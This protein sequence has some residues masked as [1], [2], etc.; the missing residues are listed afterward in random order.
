MAHGIRG[1]TAIIAMLIAATAHSA[2]EEQTPATTP[3]I[4]SVMPV[5]E[6]FTSSSRPSA[7]GHRIAQGA[8]S[9]LITPNVHVETLVESLEQ[10]WGM[11]LIDDTTLVV[12]ERP[13]RLLRVDL[14]DNTTSSIGGLPGVHAQGQGGLLDVALHPRFSE[15]RYL[16]LTYS[17]R[18]RG[19]TATHLGRG[20]LNAEQD[21]LE[22][23]EVLL[24]AGPGLRSNAHY[25]SRIAISDEGHVFI[26]TGDRNRKDFGP[27]HIAQ[28]LS[29][30][31]G[32]ILRVLD[33]GLIPADNPFV[34]D[35]R[36]DDAI[37][38]YG[39]RNPQGLAFHPQTGVLWSNEHGEFNGDEINIIERGGNYGWPIATWG[40]DYRTRERFAPTPPEVEDTI[41][42]VYWWSPEHP[43]GFPPSG[44]AF[45]FGDMFPEWS[46]H[47]LM[48]NLAHRYLGVFSVDRDESGEIAI[49]MVA[50]VLDGRHRIR[51]VLVHPDGS[52]FV[53]TAENR[54][55]L[56]RLS[57]ASGVA[58]AAFD[59]HDLRLLPA[60]LSP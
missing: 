8:D 47:L 13:G 9:A 27:D 36:A 22:D 45:Y 19:G 42:P 43:E 44:L 46:G 17:A 24:V 39:H 30:R 50:R 32:K 31:H 18:T 2:T 55:P 11:A 4:K 15:N 29:T 41:N 26:S 60:K 34:N 25:G 56:L 12:T 52:I 35:R 58:T 54:G 48:G 49:E 28:D 59:G 16:Y 14:R 51:D 10:A 53:L 5:V 3:L 1:A 38:S 20:R 37:W 23:F 21:T 40:V 33:D 6:E 57:R 7:A